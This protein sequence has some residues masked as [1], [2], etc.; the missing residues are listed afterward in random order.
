MKPSECRFLRIN[1]CGMT[2]RRMWP[3]GLN[4]PKNPEP[5]W[6]Q[7]FVNTPEQ[8]NLCWDAALIPSRSMPRRKSQPDCP[9]FLLTRATR[10]IRI[11]TP[12]GQE[13]VKFLTTKGAFKTTKKNSPKCSPSFSANRRQTASAKAAKHESPSSDGTGTDTPF[14]SL[15]RVTNMSPSGS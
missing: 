11:R 7:A 8:V 10:L 13:T 3:S 9:L 12:H 2:T 6:T 4:G 14:C 1:P 5:R 15:R